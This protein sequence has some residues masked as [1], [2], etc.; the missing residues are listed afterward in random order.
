MEYATPSF[1]PEGVV[2]IG[3]REGALFC[4]LELEAFGLSH[5][6]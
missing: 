1:E 6:T 5:L 3:S 4:C 2:F